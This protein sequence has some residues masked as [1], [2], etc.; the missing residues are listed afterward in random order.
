MGTN[1]ASVEKLSSLLT[2]V[3]YLVLHLISGLGNAVLS[4]VLWY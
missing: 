3:V 4:S 2:Y 1:P